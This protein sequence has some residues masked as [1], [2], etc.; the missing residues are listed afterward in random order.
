MPGI[1]AY[2]AGLDGITRPV[3]EAADALQVIARYGVGVDAVDLDAAQERGIIVTNTPGANTVSVAELTVA[4]ILAL[5]RRL[6]EAVQATRQ[7]QWP[8][9]SGLTLQG[10]VIGLVGFGAIGQQVA[11]RLSAFDCTLLAYDPFPSEARAGELGVR[12]L[13]LEELLPQAE[14][15]SLHCPATP[16]TRG[17]VNEAFLDKMKPGA[18]LVNTA[19][20]ELV[21]EPALLHALQSG[22]LGGAAMDVFSRQPPPADHPLLSLPQVIVT[23]HM[24]AHTDGAIAAMGEGALENCLAV[25]RGQPPPNRVV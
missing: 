16:E 12:L 10:K 7:G 14:V 1:D 3:I 5:A 11:R 15:L 22:K 23:P 20:G 24:G 6:L 25:L 17:L 8:R 19:R 4:L 21:D 2:I 13:P 9:L 18:L